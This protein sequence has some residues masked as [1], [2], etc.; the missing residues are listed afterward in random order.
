MDLQSS[1]FP[2][3]L[4]RC[5]TLPIQ[6]VGNL[7]VPRKLRILHRSLIIYLVKVCGKANLSVLHLDRLGG[8]EHLD[9][10]VIP[11]IGYSSF[12][13]YVDRIYRLHRS[14]CIRDHI[15]DFFLFAV[16]DI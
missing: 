3:K 10:A 4:L 15:D 16:L 7:N 12:S 9:R 1:G 13:E 6:S 2:G 8:I 14:L 11:V 5:D